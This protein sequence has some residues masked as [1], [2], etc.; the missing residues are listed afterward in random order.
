MKRKLIIYLILSG[1]ILFFFVL[2]YLSSPYREL[3]PYEYFGKKLPENLGQ[4]TK[5]ING[6][7]TILISNDNPSESFYIDQI[8]V[9][10]K[11]YKE[12]TAIDSNLFEH[13]RYNY[14]KFW[15]DPIYELL[16]VTY[17]N[18]FDAQNY[19]LSLRGN[20]PTA[21]QWNLAASGNANL[22]YPWGN[23]LPNLSRANLDGYYQ[24]LIPAGWL[25]EGAS[26]F[27]VLD[28]TGN[29]R[30]WVLDE[31]YED[32][33]NKILKGG[34]DYDSFTDGR[35]ESYFDHGPTSSGFNRGFRCVYP[36]Q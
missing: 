3:R 29:V 12:R 4:T 36:A 16:P 23:S 20:L 24:M 18:W 27:G 17:V 9:T 21:Q 11:D 8:P 7:K 22:D 28:M 32:N 5:T 19:C 25:P 31:L 13:Y 2:I 1:N 6:R 15:N 35:I 34:G 30:E 26:P 10:I 14:T 33:D